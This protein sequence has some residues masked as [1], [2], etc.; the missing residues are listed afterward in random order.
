MI[1]GAWRLLNDQLKGQDYLLGKEFS[2]VDILA[3]ALVTWTKGLER[4]ALAEGNDNVKQ[5]TKRVQA[6]PSWAEARKREDGW[7]INLKDFEREYFPDTKVNAN[8]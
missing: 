2:V 8:L 4:M 3:G 7:E 6:R 5:W 1:E